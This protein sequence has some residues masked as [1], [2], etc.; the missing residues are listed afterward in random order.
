[1]KEFIIFKV[2]IEKNVL[3]DS[4]F[5]YIIINSLYEPQNIN[6]WLYF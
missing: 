2:K 3:T 6:K 4:N 1:M 5:N